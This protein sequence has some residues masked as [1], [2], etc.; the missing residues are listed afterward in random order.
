MYT[1]KTEKNRKIYSCEICDFHTSDKSAFTR[2]CSTRKHEEY[3]NIGKNVYKKTEESI[4]SRC[5]K[6]YK[7]RMGLWKH[8][9]KCNAKISC[10][11]E[12]II[13][14]QDDDIVCSEPIKN[15]IMKLVEQNMLLSEQTNELKNMF[16]QQNK[17][18][19]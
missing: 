5:G 8:N 3:T 11:S 10:E 13:L 17:E 15:Y 16:I 12:N 6:E 2:H 18:F 9:K 4:C 14:Q 7:T 1:E 19:T